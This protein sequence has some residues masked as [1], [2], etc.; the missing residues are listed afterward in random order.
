MSFLSSKLQI[1]VLHSVLFSLL[2]EAEYMGRVCFSPLSPSLSALEE[3]GTILQSALQ[4]VI[5]VEI[6]VV[7]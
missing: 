7:V 5:I 6:Y 4:A 2:Q 1:T 3:V